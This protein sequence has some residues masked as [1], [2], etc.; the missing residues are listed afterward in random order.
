MIEWIDTP[1]K[2][3]A[4]LGGGAIMLYAIEVPDGVW[5]SCVSGCKTNSQDLNLPDRETA[6]DV[7]EAYA[8]VLI[9]RMSE[10]V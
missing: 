4:K 3:L 5:E 7:A 6:K 1:G 10:Q 9:K 2:S 8:R